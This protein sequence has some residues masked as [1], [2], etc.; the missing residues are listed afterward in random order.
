MHR[1]ERNEYPACVPYRHELVDICP[2]SSMPPYAYCVFKVLLSMQTYNQIPNLST[3]NGTQKDHR[4]LGGLFVLN[5][6]LSGY[7]FSG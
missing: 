1:I 7:A 2:F 3:T 6:A 4:F 5:T